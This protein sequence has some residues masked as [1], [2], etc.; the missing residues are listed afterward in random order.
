MLRGL[1]FTMSRWEYVVCAAE[2]IAE[3][4]I[5]AEKKKLTVGYHVPED[6]ELLAALGEI[7]IRHGHIDHQVK[8]M[9]RTFTGVTAQEAMDATARETSWNLR[10]RAKKLARSRLGEGA[11]LVKVQALLE[12]SGRITDR[13][14]ALVHI[15]CGKDNDG[16]PVAATN[17]LKTWEPLPTVVALNAL[18]ADML[19]L[20]SDFLSAR[21][22][23][24][25]IA[26]ALLEKK[27]SAR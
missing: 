3:Y 10:D 21:S 19:K 17:D 27:N 2:S 24:G 5:V 4:L 14:N 6:R 12:R 18:S 26:Q 22:K 7:S 16:N 13:R 11:A 23:F 25:F 1:D 8:M 9:I 20:V 15:L